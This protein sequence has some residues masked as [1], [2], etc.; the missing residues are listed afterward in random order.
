[1]IDEII[2]ATDYL[3]IVCPLMA[4]LM[5]ELFS[6]KKQM[7]LMIDKWFVGC[8]E[9]I[10]QISISSVEDVVVFRIWKRVDPRMTN[11]KIPNSHGPIW[12]PSSFFYINRIVLERVGTCLG[13]NCGAFGF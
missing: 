9:D 7:E 8:H 6:F 12:L 5:I 2:K 3:F 1:M 11:K 4:V 13:W 10:D